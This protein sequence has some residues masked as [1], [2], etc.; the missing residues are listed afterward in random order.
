MIYYKEW[1]FS[2][3]NA[4]LIIGLY[5]IDIPVRIISAFKPH[6]HIVSCCV[7]VGFTFTNVLEMITSGLY[8]ECDSGFGFND[9][10]IGVDIQ[11]YMSLLTDYVTV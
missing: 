7:R 9:N 10:V 2:N 1:S 6:A 11:K 3:A 5:I 8:R 4:E